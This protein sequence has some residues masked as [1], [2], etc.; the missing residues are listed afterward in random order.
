MASSSTPSSA[1]SCVTGPTLKVLSWN[2]DG[3]GE[4]NVVPRTRAAI[5]EIKQEDPD[6]VML[7]ELVPMTFSMFSTTF[8]STFLIRHGA[9][10]DRFTKE[11]M[12]PAK[13][14]FTAIL[15]KKTRFDSN[16]IPPIYRTLPF[17]NSKMSRTLLI[18]EVRNPFSNSIMGR[19][20]LIVEVRKPPLQ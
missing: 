16:L 3:L 18:V 19:T 15:L 20:L 14:Y 11:A 1:S 12:A 5:E 10:N 7:Q 6:V 17:S 4:K 2:L 13:P 8:S 9:K